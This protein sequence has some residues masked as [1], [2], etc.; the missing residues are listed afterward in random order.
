MFIEQLL[1]DQKI[2]DKYLRA[3]GTKRPS[4]KHLDYFF[5]TDHCV[6]CLKKFDYSIDYFPVCKVYTLI[7]S[8]LI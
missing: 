1:K 5:N 2:F 4:K 8:Q 7:T 3:D 6:I